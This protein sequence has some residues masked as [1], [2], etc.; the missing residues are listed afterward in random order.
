MDAFAHYEPVEVDEDALPEVTAEEV[1]QH[2]TPEDLWVIIYG[3]VYDV[4]EWQH[5]HPGGDYILQEW[6]GKDA[7]EMFRSVQH[8]Q[9]ALGIRSNFIVARLKKPQAKL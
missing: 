1:A 8:S 7:S 3:R 6:G 4:T 9:D 5:S 2:N